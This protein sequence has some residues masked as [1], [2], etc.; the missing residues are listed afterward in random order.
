MADAGFQKMEQK[1]P[2]GLLFV[3]S[4]MGPLFSA[5]FPMVLDDR[6]RPV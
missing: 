4:L 5:F 1:R 3:L 6:I 2:A